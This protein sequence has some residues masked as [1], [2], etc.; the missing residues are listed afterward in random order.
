MLRRLLIQNVCGH[1]P[2]FMWGKCERAELCFQ[3]CLILTELKEE[4][5]MDFKLKA[6][7]GKNE[8]VVTE[9]MRI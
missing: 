7:P 5:S 9:E 2:A 3:R 4:S 1:K 6:S 8:G